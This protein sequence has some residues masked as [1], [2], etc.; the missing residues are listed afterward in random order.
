MEWFFLTF[1]LLLLFVIIKYCNSQKTHIRFKNRIALLEDRSKR[2]QMNPH[3]ILNA[4]NGVQ[5]IMLMHGERVT[6]LYMWM[7][8]KLIR[9][10]LDNSLRESIPLEEEIE[11]LTAYMELQKMRMNNKFDYCF[12]LKVLRKEKAYN[13]PPMLIQPLIENAIMHGITPLKNNGILIIKIHE[14]DNETLEVT[15]ED[16]GIGIPA[17]QIRKKA[18][19][20]GHKSQATKIFKERIAIFNQFQNKKLSFDMCSP[21]D[22]ETG[23]GT[24]CIITIPYNPILKKEPAFWWNNWTLFW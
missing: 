13:I 20:H 9:Y 5:G 8:A 7:L 15:V 14:K 16:N 17:A 6:N 22:F 4:L 11:Y 24:R 18:F 19:K 12:D 21:R 3:F 2:A 10:T 1:T 23:A